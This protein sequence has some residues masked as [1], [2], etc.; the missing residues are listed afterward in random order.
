MAADILSSSEDLADLG[1]GWKKKDQIGVCIGGEIYYYYHQY[2]K[3][4]QPKHQ[5]V[6]VNQSWQV[7]QLVFGASQ[8]FAEMMHP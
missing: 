6:I 2:K 3:L 1:P 7:V 5:P 8:L 4:R